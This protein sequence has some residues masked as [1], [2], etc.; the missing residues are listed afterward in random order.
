MNPKDYTDLVYN[1]IGAA[2]KVHSELS[3][4]LLE[5]LYTEALHM[6]LEAFRRYRLGSEACKARDLPVHRQRVE[7]RCG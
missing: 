4:G 2:M 5:P 1:V 3:W 7:R 6:E